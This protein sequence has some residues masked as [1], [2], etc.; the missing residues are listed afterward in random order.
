MKVFFIII[1]PRWLG[2][3]NLFNAPYGRKIECRTKL[4][5]WFWH[6]S[7]KYE[8]RSKSESKKRVRSFLFLSENKPGLG[9][10]SFPESFLSPPN[11]K[12]RVAKTRIIPAN[13]WP[14][15]RLINRKET[16]PHPLPGHPFFPTTCRRR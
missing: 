1:Y 11:S 9:V 8:S 12:R 6:K 4:D 13:R 3:N 7:T 10:N 5:S 2:N 16:N 15:Q 14:R